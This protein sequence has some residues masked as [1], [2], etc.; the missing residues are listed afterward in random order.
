M[1]TRNASAE[2]YFTDLI[3][4]ETQIRSVSGSGKV[5]FKMDQ[6]K[7]LLILIACATVYGGIALLFLIYCCRILFK[8]ATKDHEEEENHPK[9][10][11]TAFSEVEVSVCVENKSKGS[12]NEGFLV[13]V[14]VEGNGAKTFSVVSSVDQKEEDEEKQKPPL[15]TNEEEGQKDNMDNNPAA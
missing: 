9:S 1:K 11:A 8:C 14:T 4:S 6:P 12:V 15:T 7:T 13:D 10:N 3:N 5:K 2:S